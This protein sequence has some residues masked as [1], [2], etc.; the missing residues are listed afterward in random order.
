MNRTMSIPLATAA[1]LVA[2]ALAQAQAPADI[3]GVRDNAR[4]FSPAAVEATSRLLR[5]I[6]ADSDGK[7]QVLIDTV[8]T[9][10]GKTARE[11]ALANA[12]KAKIKGLAVVIAKKEKSVFVEPSRSAESAF[13]KAERQRVVDAFT[14]AFKKGDFDRGLT[15][16]ANE[17]RFTTLKTGVRD[18]AGMFSAAALEKAD[19]A[20]DTLRTHSRTHVAIETIPSLEGKTPSEAATARARDLGIR[21][22][23]VLLSKNDHKV[24][25]L[26][27]ASAEKTFT[28]TRRK[29]IDDAIVSAFKAGEFDRGLTDAVETI[30]RA[31]GSDTSI[32][33]AKVPTLTIPK[34]TTPAPTPPEPR[35]EPPGAATS[36]AAKIEK[37]MERPP[38]PAPAKVASPEPFKAPTE[39]T[40]PI[41]PAVPAAVPQAVPGGGGSVLPILLVGG[42][43]ILLLLW[44]ASRLFRRSP[45]PGYGPGGGNSPYPPQ[46]GPAPGPRPAYGPQPPQGY[47]P[48]PAPGYGY[49]PPPQQGGGGFMS[50]AL[51]GLGGAIAGNIL[52]DQ[53]GRRHEGQG[54][55]PI[56]HSGNVM[57]PGSGWPHQEGPPPE[58]YDPNAGTG[59]DWGTPDPASA[60]AED[61][62]TG[63]T[64][65][66][67]E[68]AATGG[69]WGTPDN[70]D[71]G[72]GGD[73]G[74]PDEPADTG[75][76]WGGDA[77]GGSD[78][79]GG[80]W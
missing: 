17:L 73:W 31:A 69:D 6:Q 15:D 45:T 51:G 27:T 48:G 57:P 72:T 24:Y 77:G 39:P 19:T 5:E 32:A 66:A 38:A 16:A 64:W 56:H 1:V 3:P 80:S 60:P 18:A 54:E 33:A 26:S 29:A 8:E 12:E 7:W 47:G 20:L 74:T 58:S 70:A 34:A 14:R 2:A 50:G 23:Y 11:V 63:G 13:P 40:A 36:T 35:S 68:E 37:L 21:G 71:P 65:G 42:G 76:D 78:D 52:Y 62:G 44:L 49:G 61:P 30:R 43:G 9:L 41:Q 59:G 53:F 46:G 79:Q 22:L 10:G 75:G 25:T 28:E 55:G 4:L 67:P